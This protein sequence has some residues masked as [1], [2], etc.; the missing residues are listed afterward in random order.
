MI[1]GDGVALGHTLAL[2]SPT[3]T[4]RA[5]AK[6]MHKAFEEEHIGLGGSAFLLL[7][8]KEIHCSS[9]G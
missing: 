1:V 4:M 8:L 3:A 9:D 6:N 7:L 2:E 5:D